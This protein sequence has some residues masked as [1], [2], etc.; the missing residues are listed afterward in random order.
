MFIIVPFLLGISRWQNL[1]L[2]QKAMFYVVFLAVLVDGLT[3]TLKELG[4]QNNLWVY[5]LSVPVHWVLLIKVFTKEFIKP[6]PRRVLNV[7]IF[8]F[9][10]FS[11]IN[12]TF[13]QPL[14]ELNTSA[15]V[16]SSII[17]L[18]LAVS[19]FYGLIKQPRFKKLESQPMIWFNTGLILY[20]SGSLLLFVFA[21]FVNDQSPDFIITVWGLNIVFVVLLQLFYAVSLWVS[22]QD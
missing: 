8:G 22:P 12:S 19:Y 2:G 18:T 14:N 7:L 3:M 4:I 11:L 21:N 17:T 15:I 20:N 6:I 13:F 5:H 1:T 9:T 10:F 16:F